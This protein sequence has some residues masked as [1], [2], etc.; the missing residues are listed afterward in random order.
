[1]EEWVDLPGYEGLYQVSKTGYIKSLPR[2][3]T[4]GGIMRGHLDKKGYVIIT[5]RKDG[6]QSSKRLHRLIA[7][8]FIPNPDN[9][10]EVNHRNENKVDNRVENLEWC[11]S[12][13]NH[14]YGSRTSRAAQ[15]CGKAIVCVETGVKY[16]GAKW[17]ATELNL[18]P[19]AIT[20]ALKNPNRTCGGCHW[21]YL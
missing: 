19:S 4:Q 18:D 8:T 11:T 9:L 15:S 20:K 17:A 16:Q 14:E 12:A 6:V 5:L 10:P 2:K 1:M 7:E 21:K 3:G 13:Y